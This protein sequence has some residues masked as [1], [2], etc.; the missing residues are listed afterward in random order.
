MPPWKR[1]V[2]ICAS[3]GAGFA[4]ALALIVGGL[5]WHK[6]RPTPLS[7]WNVTA[8]QASWDR[9]DFEFIAANGK[10]RTIVFYYALENQTDR[11]YEVKDRTS[12]VIYEQ[13]SGKHNLELSEDKELSLDYPLFVPARRRVEIPLHL[14]VTYTDEDEKK[15]GKLPDFMR[16]TSIKG[17]VLFDKANRYQINFPQGW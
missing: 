9:M 3:A 5:L 15:Y 11:D 6:Y 8:L 16:G 12:M 14:N 4:F 10:R 13:F 17:F 2:V 7:P 1:L